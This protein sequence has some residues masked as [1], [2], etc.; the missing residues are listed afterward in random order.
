MHTD[1][2]S[3]ARDTQRAAVKTSPEDLDV[4][5]L[6]VIKRGGALITFN[7]TKIKVALTQAFLDTEGDNAA[8]SNRVHGIVNDLTDEVL[9][10]LRRYLHTGGHVQVEEI[11]DQVELVLM[12]NEFRKVARSYILYREE[13][14]KLREDHPQNT[15]KESV[16]NITMEDG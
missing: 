5:N 1:I 11:Q 10:G 2:E 3:S 8:L 4:S 6:K 15:K 16:I 13:H 14:K 9:I 12:R 7:E